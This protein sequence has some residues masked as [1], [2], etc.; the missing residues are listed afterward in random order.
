MLAGITLVA[1]VMLALGIA[2]PLAAIVSL[3]P[4]ART[5]TS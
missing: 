2:T 3:V 5:I 1:A 4:E